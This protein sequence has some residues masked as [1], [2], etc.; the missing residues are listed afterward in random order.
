MSNQRKLDDRLMPA[1]KRRQAAMTRVARCVSGN[2]PG[3]AKVTELIEAQNELRMSEAE[4]SDAAKA[5][6]RAEIIKTIEDRETLISENP[7]NQSP[8]TNT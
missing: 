3:C 5:L 8:T 1:I 6:N 7:E 2:L 4:C